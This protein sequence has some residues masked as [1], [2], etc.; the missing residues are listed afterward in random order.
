MKLS[1]KKRIALF[2]TLAV[3]ITTA[4]VFVIIY[5]VVYLSSYRHLDTDILLEKEEIINSLDWKED[6]IIVIKM[7]EWEEAEHKKVEV[8]PTFIQIVN[9]KDKM[10]FRSENLRSNHFLFNPLIAKEY[11]YNTTIDNQRLRLGQFPV[12]NDEGKIIGQLTIGVSQ[13]ESYYV[14]HNLFITLCISFLILLL[15]LYCVI[16]FAA[17]K[18]IA[19][20]HRLIQAASGINDVNINTRLPLPENEDEI[21]KLATTINELLNRIDSS[22][23]QQKQF[24]ADASHEIR[25]PLA[26]IKGTLEVLLRKKREPEQYEE[27]I[28][29]VLTQTDRLNHLLDQLLQ[30]A[31]LESGSIKKETVDL[32]NILKEAELKFGKQIQE[33]KICVTSTIAESVSVYANSIFLSVIVDN[34][35]SNAVKY[36]ATNGTIN[37][38]WNIDTK[39][40]SITNDGTVITQQQIPL[41]FNRFYRADDSRNSLIPGNGLGLSIVKKL[42]DIQHIEIIV[43]SSKSNTIFSLKFPA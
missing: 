28:K 16:Y 1:F 18:A 31:R 10:I 6:S 20:V 41:L 36:A 43:S 26:A 21:Y 3:A 40:F 37:C 35:F 33:K 12:Q 25:T 29:E 24:T 23:Q 8:N 9:N 5:A 27:K 2:N 17:S 4:I 22:I 30:L 7:P 19:P 42:S 14:L 11:F 34:L 38:S 13:Q 15:V 39:T 32:N